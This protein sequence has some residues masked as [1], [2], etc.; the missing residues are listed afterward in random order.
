MSRNLECRI[1]HSQKISHSQATEKLVT[2]FP[3]DKSVFFFEK[4]SQKNEVLEQSI[5][6]QEY[7]IRQQNADTV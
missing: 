3:S 7:W 5:S 4:K 2:F 1:I 6:R